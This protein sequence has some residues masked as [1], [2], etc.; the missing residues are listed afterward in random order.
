MEVAMV[1]DKAL[2][3]IMEKHLEAIDINLENMIES[4]F[5]HGSIHAFRESIRRFR[6]LMF[7]FIHNIRLS[8]YRMI[9]FVSKKFFNMTSLIREIDVFESE[10]GSFMSKETLDK[11]SKIK[12]PL[13]ERLVEELDETNGF[14]FQHVKIHIRPFKTQSKADKYQLLRQSELFN[15]FLEKDDERFKEE[16][17][18]HAKRMLAKKLLYVHGILM[19][20]KSDL[21]D[22]NEALERFQQMAKLLHDVCVNLRFVG[23]YKLD[24]E[25]LITKLV[26]DHKAFSDEAEVQYERVCLAMRAFMDK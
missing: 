26:L 21:S 9:E 11:L 22:I 23:H 1:E 17:Y 5:G 4:S 10:Y 18:I 19:P 14:R 6:A 7:F 25:A 24:D 12:E 2:S 8:D 16:K 3:M 15:S 20:D 13:L